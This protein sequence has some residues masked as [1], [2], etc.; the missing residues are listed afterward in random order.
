M[1]RG[2][3]VPLVTWR[4]FLESTKPFGC[5][6][7]RD[8][9]FIVLG[10]PLENTVTYKPGTRFAPDV[11]RS[12]SCNV[13]FNSLYTC[14]DMDAIGYYDLGNIGVVVGDNPSSLDRVSR[15]VEGVLNDYPRRH[16][17][18]LGGEHTLTYGVLRGFL[19]SFRRGYGLAYIVFDAHLDLRSSYLGYRYSHACTQ[20][21][22]YRELGIK[23]IILGVR[24]WSRGELDYARDNGIVF[25]KV[26]DLWSRIDSVI[27][28]IGKV[29][30]SSNRVYLSIDI[31]VFDPSYAPGVSNPEALGI[32]PWTFFKIAKYIIDS[33]SDHSVFIGFDIV[34]V[35]PVQDVNDV[36]S[37]LATRIVLELTSMLYSKQL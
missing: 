34:E 26:N 11:I 2:W 9:P 5:V 17:V 23:P 29:I 24:G 20:Y 1:S 18:I 12:V 25:F 8:S 28:Y 33:V 30:S 35:N 3:C 27:D 31:D 37:V 32:D 13:E 4:H 10:V 21:L 16:L 14:M 7:N 22:V 6:E 19:K 15:V 36:T